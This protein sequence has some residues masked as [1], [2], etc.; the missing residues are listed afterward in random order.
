[1]ADKKSARSKYSVRHESV[2]VTVGLVIAAGTA[3]LKKFSQSLRIKLLSSCS[4]LLTTNVIIFLF[5]VNQFSR[6]ISF[7]LIPPVGAGLNKIK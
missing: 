6:L 7:R 2:A 3:L 1:M 4:F 5:Q